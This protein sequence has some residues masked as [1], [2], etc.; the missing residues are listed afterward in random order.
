MKE[1]GLNDI[2][3]KRITDE[4]DVV[5]CFR[6]NEERSVYLLRR[7]DDGESVLLKCG[8]GKSGKL[9]ENEHSIVSSLLENKDCDFAIKP[10]DIFTENDNVYYLREYVKGSTLE[11]IVESGNVFPEKEAISI[12]SVL[13]GIVEK[14]HKLNPPVICRDLNPSN[15]LITDDGSIRIIDFDS[16]KEYDKNAV[17]DDGCLGTKEMAAPEQFGYSQSDRRTDVYAMGMLL[18]YIMTG[19]YDRNAGVKGKAGRVIARSIEFNPDDRYSDISKMRKALHRGVNKKAAAITGAAAVVL[20]AAVFSIIYLPS[21]LRKEAVFVNPVIEQEVRRQLDKTESETIYLDEVD[22]IESLLFIG[23]KVFDSWDDVELMHTFLFNEYAEIPVPEPQYV[24][25]DD[26]EMMSGLKYLAIE[27]LG[28]TELPVLPETLTHFAASDNHITDISVLSGCSEL[29]TAWLSANFGI[30][31]ISSLSNCSN[32]K[33]VDLACC[34]ELDNIDALRGKPLEKLRI[35]FT[36]VTSVPYINEFE[37][38]NDIIV[39]NIDTETINAIS[40]IDSLMHLEMC[41]C[42]NL[43]E[44]GSI[45]RLP[46][47]KTLILDTPNLESIDGISGLQALESLGIINA[48]LNALPQE[49]ALMKVGNISL[50]DCSITDFTPVRDCTNLSFLTV[51]SELIDEIAMQMM[52]TEIVVQGF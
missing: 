8:K 21:L 47:L 48:P 41:Q 42:E 4:Y 40:G 6:H 46:N 22:D 52:G 13:C 50:T 23:D 26:L 12:I 39:G 44:L 2:F 37:K 36:E 18:L 30:K 16:A 33:S 7:I 34:V 15:I 10:V 51:D 11:M 25:L 9:L 20:C 3:P 27:K 38:L 45:C 5:T 43:T 35:N 31:D 29:E 24:P 17:Y 49:M 28:I 1:Y 19:S 14:L 32:L